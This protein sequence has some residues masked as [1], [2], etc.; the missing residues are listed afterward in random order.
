MSLRDSQIQ[1]LGLSTLISGMSHN[2]PHAPHISSVHPRNEFPSP[3]YL[4]LPLGF[5][6]GWTSLSSWLSCTHQPVVSV[7]ACLHSLNI[8]SMHAIQH[9]PACKMQRRYSTIGSACRLG[10]QCKSSHTLSCACNPP[11]IPNALRIV[12]RPG[13]DQTY[14][15]AEAMPT[16]PKRSDDLP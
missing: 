11:H 3:D 2:Y 10:P 4:P 9:V 13:V 15:T 7:E 8:A 14:P 5:P 16:Q 6:K 12:Y 1:V